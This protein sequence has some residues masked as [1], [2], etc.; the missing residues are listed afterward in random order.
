MRTKEG[1]LLHRYRAGEAA[2]PAHLDDYAFMVWGLLN[3]YEASFDERYL[4]AAIELERKSIALFWDNEK[5]GV[6]LT[7]DDAEALL[8]R[9]KESDDGAIPSGNA[10]QLLNLLR[11][12][13]ITADTQLESKASNSYARS[14]DKSCV[15]PPAARISSAAWPSLSGRHSKL[16]WR[17]EP[18]RMQS[19]SRTD[20]LHTRC[21]CPR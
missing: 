11:I 8:A 20:C 5:G 1:R 7:A 15:R 21:R 10:V 19:K 9:P 16:F 3:L 18:L 13:R 12:A 4:Q 6:F 2:I 17:W 14:P